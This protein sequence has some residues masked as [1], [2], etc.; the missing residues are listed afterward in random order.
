MAAVREKKRTVRVR[1]IKRMAKRVLGLAMVVVVVVVV[2]WLWL[3]RGSNMLI[4][5]REEGS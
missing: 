3:I 2:V 5:L 1:G 4:A